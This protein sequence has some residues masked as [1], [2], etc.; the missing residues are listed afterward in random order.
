[1]S[2][3]P[4][5]TSRATKDT[6]GDTT[7][8]GPE[9]P[10]VEEVATDPPAQDMSHIDTTPG[11]RAEPK[12]CP[13]CGEPATVAPVMPWVHDAPEYCEQHCPPHLRRLVV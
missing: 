13:V 7:Q 1:M 9:K 6:K 3:T 11:D 12:M 5:K 8:R 2:G 4:R 10:T